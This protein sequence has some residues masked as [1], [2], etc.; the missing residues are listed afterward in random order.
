M[1][2]IFLG[3]GGSAGVPMI[4]CECPVC[5]SEDPLNK[6]LRPSGLLRAGDKILLIDSG[7]DFREQA[8]KFDINRLDGVLLTH[9]HFDHVAGLDE[10]RAYYLM[11]REPLSVLASESTLQDL[12]RRYDYLFREKSWGMSL[13]AQ[14]DFHVLDNERGE[15]LFCGI[16]LRYMTYEQ[17]GMQVNGYRFGSFA[18]VSDIRNYPETL[19]EELTGVEIL[20]LSALRHEPSLMHFNIEEAVA[21]SRKV[22]AKQTY[23]THIGHELEHLKTNEQLPSGCALA[24]DGLRLAFNYEY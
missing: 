20:V 4:G 21:F 19:F 22:G 12:K 18:Y 10:L 16:P 3:T 5:R 7:P 9:S 23:F 24:H 8:L 15:A 14:L 1:E 2:F 6:R 13:A 11:S 17:G